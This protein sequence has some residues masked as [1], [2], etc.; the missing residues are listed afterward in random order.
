V[1]AAHAGGCHDSDQDERSQRHG[2]R[3]RCW[4]VDTVCLGFGSPCSGP[5][6]FLLERWASFPQGWVRSA[7]PCLPARSH[8]TH[9]S[10]ADRCVAGV[11]GNTQAPQRRVRLDDQTMLHHLEAVMT[12]AL[13]CC[14]WRGRCWALVMVSVASVLPLPSSS[15][16]TC[17]HDMSHVPLSMGGVTIVTGAAC[18]SLHF[19]RSLTLTAMTGK[20]SCTR[21]LHRA[22]THIRCSVSLPQ[23]HAQHTRAAP[24]CL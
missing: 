3:R 24:R 4:S 17:V 7:A 18:T 13:R 1:S 19:T 6:N 15:A 10:F 20:H 9:Q 11:T 14:L 16:A 21:A 5:L 22:G 12:S 2:G 8:S 23:N